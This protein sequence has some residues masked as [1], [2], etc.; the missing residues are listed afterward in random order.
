[1]FLLW[2][3]TVLSLFNDIVFVWLFLLVAL[4][5][6]LPDRPARLTLNMAGF[7]VRRETRTA[8]PD[9]LDAVQA[10]VTRD[11][12]SSPA[13]PPPCSHIQTS[14]R[15]TTTLQTTSA[16]S[17]SSP[18]EILL[19]TARPWAPR[20]PIPVVLITSTL[21]R[22]SVVPI[23][24][25]SIA[26]V[27]S[28]LSP[29]RSALPHTCSAHLQAAPQGQ[30]ASFPLATLLSSSSALLV[31]LKAFQRMLSGLDVVWLGCLFSYWR[32]YDRIGNKP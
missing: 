7:K 9:W 12:H 22:V 2:E 32:F 10:R 30:R 13:L 24:P 20:C 16:A 14:P 23:E 21:A 19:P 5:L 15:A 6:S 1:M 25:V 17:S 27:A 31:I 11:T 8:A 4:R 26:S 28:V 18:C 3:H 29:P